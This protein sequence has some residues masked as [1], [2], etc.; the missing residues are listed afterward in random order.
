MLLFQR[1]DS[2]GPPFYVTKSISNSIISNGYMEFHYWMCHDVFSLLLLTV[3]MF[4][5]FPTYQLH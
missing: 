3:I 4:C 2:T 1:Y 5:F